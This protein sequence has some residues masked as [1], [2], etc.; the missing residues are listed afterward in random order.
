MSDFQLSDRIDIISVM[1]LK[2]ARKDNL[3]TSGEK[4]GID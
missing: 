3:K 4:N 1:V 2:K